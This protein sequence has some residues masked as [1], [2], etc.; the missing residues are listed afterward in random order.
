MFVQH[1]NYY[2]N[3]EPAKEIADIT[4][5]AGAKYVMSV[6]PIS[7]GALKT[8]REYGAD[9]AVGDGQPLG[10]SI[11]FGGPYLGFMACTDDLVIRLPGIIVAKT[12]D[13][14]GRVV[15]VLTHQS[16]EHNIRRENA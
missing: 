13:S 4:H 2:G 15:Y 14:K 10:L 12:H 8:P 1:P 11:A 3:L 9:I 7:L 16:R 5:E 6:N